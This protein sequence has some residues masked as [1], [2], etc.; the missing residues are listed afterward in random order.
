[1]LKRELKKDH[2]E[3]QQIRIIK[4]KIKHYP[5]KSKNEHIYL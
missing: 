1:M 2:K 4:T 3:K 5:G